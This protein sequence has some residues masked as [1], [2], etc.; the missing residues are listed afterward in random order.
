MQYNKQ[1]RPSAP[2]RRHRWRAAA[3]LCTICPAINCSTALAAQL[4]TQRAMDVSVEVGEYAQLAGADADEE[5]GRGSA[6]EHDVEV[7]RQVPFCK[8]LGADAL[9][10]LR[11]AAQRVTFSRGEAVVTEGE[12]GDSMYIVESGHFNVQAEADGMLWNFD[13]PGDFFGEL[14]VLRQQQVRSATVKAASSSATC[15][16]LARQDVEPVLAKLKKASAKNHASYVRQ[17]GRS[18]RTMHQAPRWFEHPAFAKLETVHFT[19]S[20]LHSAILLF[21]GLAP[22]VASAGKFMEVASDCAI[23]GTVPDALFGVGL[24]FFCSVWPFMFLGLAHVV[25]G[26]TKV[27]VKMESADQRAAMEVLASEGGG[28][29]AADRYRAM[30]LK[31]GYT[32]VEGEVNGSLAQESWRSSAL[33]APG[34]SRSTIDG[35]LRASCATE[36]ANMET[37]SR[38][39]TNGT[40]SMSDVMDELMEAGHQIHVRGIG[41]DGWDGTE[42]GR[43]TYENE[44]ALAKIFA[45]FG[46]CLSVKIRHRI[47]VA[48][49]ANTSWA[50][51]TMATSDAAEA[52]LAA[53]AVMAGKNKLKLTRFNKKMAKNSQ[54]AM[55][56]LGSGLAA[57]VSAQTS[58]DLMDKVGKHTTMLAAE[59]IIVKAK[60]DVLH[61]SV[62]SMFERVHGER[63]GV[64]TQVLDAHEFEMLRVEFEEADEDGDGALDKN[65]L[66]G[67]LRDL[68]GI[69]LDPEELEKASRHLDN[70]GDGKL[71]FEEFIAWWKDGTKGQRGR[72]AFSRLSFHGGLGLER[73]LI[74]DR[75]LN[76]L[77]TQA[78][79]DGLLCAILLGAAATLTRKTVILSRCAC[80][81]SR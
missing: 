27:Q 42:E 59:N 4:L 45:P 55:R 80:C 30:K 81:P 71:S 12:P 29:T 34:S 63:I 16:R 21:L 22:F 44:Q 39:E 51:V 65:E 24:F 53:P 10:Q 57:T 41:V 54:G 67:L 1:P 31:L 61:E 77:H 20:R 35:S 14:C 78:L 69:D 6:A 25:R 70:D 79:L 58:Q 62:T 15:L 33:Q 64:G 13:K 60:R 19:P 37:H 11:R 17:R 36:I 40:G 73:Q 48:D 32:G 68:F 56:T 38:G 18:F 43:G 49:G 8:D 72:G 9:R 66:A 5:Q 46:Q 47:D 52:A 74:D 3:A 50:L 2:G 23:V 28:R 76:Y 7:L 75:Q 26:A